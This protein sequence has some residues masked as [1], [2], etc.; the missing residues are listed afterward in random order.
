MHLGNGWL[1]AS[2]SLYL[3]PPPL[4]NRL[5]AYLLMPQYVL[6]AVLLSGPSTY[7]NPPP[8]LFLATC[9]QP[10]GYQFPVV[11]LCVCL[12]SAYDYWFYKEGPFSSIKAFRFAFI[13]SLWWC[14]SEAVKPLTRPRREGR[15]GAG[16]DKAAVI[17]FNFL[18]ETKYL[19][20]I[21]LLKHTN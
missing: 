11:I 12:N 20:W 17:H 21:G 1:K 16:L 3:Q 13:F 4:Q 15:E 2:D 6:C 18:I 8:T 9:K 19:I 7:N 5:H 10:R 14:S